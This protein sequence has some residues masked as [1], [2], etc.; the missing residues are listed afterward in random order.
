MD[1]RDARRAVSLAIDRAA[2]T[3][4]LLGR[5]GAIAGGTLPPMLAA[6][7]QFMGDRR[8]DP[9]LARSLVRRFSTRA[10]ITIAV[11]SDRARVLCARIIAQ[12]LGDVGFDVEVRPLELG[13]NLARLAAG[14]FDLAL[15][16]SSEL[17][18][19]DVLRWYLHS[20]AI[21]PDG[22]NRGRVRDAAI[23]RLL[24]TGLAARSLEERRAIYAELEARIAD[25]DALIPLFH[26]DHTAVVSARA[27]SFLPSAD[28]RWSAL[29][30]L[31]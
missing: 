2:M 25:I 28:G 31:R 22:A 17:N 19:P 27:A 7:P 18:D 4:E 1:A 5:A 20:S 29:A 8:A 10:P 13:A 12:S 9:E 6:S 3:L 26:E 15:T 16:S 23:D 14:D 30:T 24:D 21:P 11:S